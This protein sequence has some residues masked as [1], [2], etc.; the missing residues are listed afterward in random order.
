M[1]SE[2]SGRTGHDG[3]A[4]SE[5]DVPAVLAV[6]HCHDGGPWGEGWLVK[7]FGLYNKY[8]VTNN[9]TGEDV[10][11]CFVLRPDRDIAAL[12]ALGEYAAHCW[13]D[14][15]LQDDLRKWVASLWEKRSLP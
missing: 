4:C 15:D 8:T 3:K 14:E 10:S 5:R 13:D 1:R 9:A 2:S 12:Y 7:E 6:H 11:E